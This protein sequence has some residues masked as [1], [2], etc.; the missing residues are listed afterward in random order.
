MWQPNRDA[1][2]AEKSPEVSGFAVTRPVQR[3]H[4]WREVLLIATFY[5][6]YTLVRDVRGD[7]PVSVFQA[8]TNAHRIISLERHLGTVPRGQHP[9]L[10]PALPGADPP[11]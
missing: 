3:S 6:L 1:L 11:V 7:R 9:A 5:V 4:W 10:V 2:L 8:T